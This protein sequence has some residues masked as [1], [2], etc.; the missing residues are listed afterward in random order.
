MKHTSFLRKKDFIFGNFIFA[1]N[2]K[3]HLIL[4]AIFALTMTLS[5]PTVESIKYSMKGIFSIA[6]IF[7][8][9]YAILLIMFFII[10][11]L[12]SFFI[13]NLTK[14]VLGEHQF[15]LLDDA[16]IESTSYNNSTHQYIA[17]DKVYTQWG[18]I[19]I[20]LSAINGHALPKRDFDSEDD[21]IAFLDFLRNKSK[22]YNFS[23]QD[24]RVFIPT[25]N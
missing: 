20:S 14:G 22:E 25:D 7:F 24:D 21:Y 6:I 17:I 2:S 13:S 5:D 19:I 18:Y 23:F 10:Y 16:F 3:I 1:I 9:N 12:Y 4:F 15:E 11:V 8:I